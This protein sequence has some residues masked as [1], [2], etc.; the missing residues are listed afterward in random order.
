MGL[1]NPVPKPD[2]LVS[3]R[4]H[5]GYLLALLLEVTVFHRHVLFLRGFLFPWDF[6]SIHLTFATFV[7][8]SIRR[9][10]LPLWEP[11]TYCG[12]PIFALIHACL[13]YPPALLATLAGNWFGPE[14]LARLLA[15]AVAL[16]IFFAGVCTFA[17][18]RRLG[19]Q[20]GAAFLSATVYQ[21][22][23]FFASQA[24]HMGAVQGGSWLPL[25]WW[26]VLEL[27]EGLRW[28]WLAILSLALSM[29]I[30]AG[31]PQVAVAAFGSALV[32][33]VVTAAFGL[34]RR[35]LPLH[36]LAA[37]LWAV[38]LAAVQV[39]PTTELTRNSIAKFRADWLKAGGGIKLQA[40]YSLVAPNYWNV[41][42]LS[43]FHG[44]GDLT[45]L[46]LYCSL[47]G[48]T[49]ALL[50]ILWKPDRWSRVF[51][52]LTVAATIWM[53]GDSTPI[54]RTIFLALPVNIR[55]GIHPE[56]TMPAFALGL[57]VLAGCGAS[58]FLR[59][60]WQVAAGFI[61][62]VD[63]IAVGSGRPFNTA[64]V[65]AEPGV[66]H[67]S[68]DGSPAL[69]ARL[70]ALAT[71][72]Q[73]PYRFDMADAPYEWSYTAP[74]LEL[75]TANGCD[76]MAPERI[77]QLRLSFAP[78]E[79]WGACYQVVNPSSPVVG[80]A[81]IR[82]LFSRSLAAPGP[83]HPIDRI[84]GYTIYEN[85]RTLPRF[86]FASRLQPAASL[87]EAARI[88]HAADFDPAQTAIVE[89]TARE[90]P[91]GRLAPG[92]VELVSYAAS[93][94]ELRTRSAGSSFLVVGDA[95]YPGWEATIDGRP[96]RLYIADVTFRGLALP[97]G[98]HRV[99]MRFVPR[100]LYRSALISMVAFLG[101]AVAIGF[102]RKPGK[103]ARISPR[104]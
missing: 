68:I 13:F 18:L 8:A 71:T 34:A 27:R 61:I 52:V 88:L 62:A 96:A 98:D 35:K 58:R 78:G 44:P 3:C 93:A 80:L 103:A 49:L 90:L 70:R 47:L 10:E 82:Y 63:L 100:I 33:A 94:V 75:P 7:A 73:P 86:F 69:A 28:S 51:G 91:S 54:G 37:W 16:Q 57:A 77:I 67:D 42:D 19:A 46:Y 4:R 20:P 99:G 40:L 9:G 65:Q 102:G 11:Y 87:A 45:F 48:L 89:A 95:W 32:L 12:T 36:V 50:A 5:A 25:V 76:P 59:P 104:P 6:R 17:L 97:A 56:F 101:A 84:A 2:F 30:F 1:A 55:I 39:I 38:L 85:S 60:R 74:V 23:C 14:H 41:F 64:S 21:L 66:T 15:I 22:G 83:F 72:A 26:A 92:E 24:Q 81:N 31:L 53:L 43:K 29:T 79:R